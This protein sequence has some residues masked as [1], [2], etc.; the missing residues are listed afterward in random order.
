MNQW[1]V[2]ELSQLTGVSVRTLH[3]YDR[4]ALLKPSLR[5]SNGYRVYSEADLLTLERIIALKFFGFS[6]TQIKLLLKDE[7]NAL[8]PFTEQIKFLQQKAE[9]LLN[10]QEVLQ[11]IIAAMDNNLE[12][13]WQKAIEMIGVYK[14]IEDVNESWAKNVLSESELKQ[15]TEFQKKL[16]GSDHKAK[17]AFEKAWANLCQ[18]VAL[19]INIDPQSA[20]AS[21][22]AEQCMTL[23]N[24][25]Y[26]QEYAHLR[27]SVWEK[28]FK[29]GA[30]D[31]RYGLNTEMVT[32]LDKAIDHYYRQRIYAV[33]NT[34]QDPQATVLP[35]WKTLMEELCG[36]D[37]SAQKNLLEAALKD[38]HIKA[39]AKAW[40]CRVYH[41]DV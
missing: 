19:H 15:Y 28:G 2:K 26:G 27:K 23:V 22:I 4:I 5:L 16:A 24:G 6:L 29:T 21:E 14:M 25:L 12:I 13:P 11:K 35:A 36:Q 7:K 37:V 10:A 3:H 40:L 34:I 1:Y 32:W 17:E 18:I 8:Q 20:K 33:L 38:E 39:I 9:T 30:I 41:L 31:E